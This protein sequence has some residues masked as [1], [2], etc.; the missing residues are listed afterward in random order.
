MSGQNVGIR[1]PSRDLTPVLRRPVEPAPKADIIQSFG[2]DAMC[3]ALRTSSAIS[4]LFGPK[5]N[6]CGISEPSEWHSER[7]L[8][9]AHLTPADQVR[10]ER[11]LYR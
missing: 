8:R 4:L 1:N 2:D 7:A 6:D 11:E 10:Q 9:R 5:A 3:R